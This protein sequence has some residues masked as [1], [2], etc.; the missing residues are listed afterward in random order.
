M[1]WFWRIRAAAFTLA[2]A[3]VVH[4]ARYALAPPQN[5]HAA[6]AAHGYFAWLMPLTVMFLFLT[7]VELASRLHRSTAKGPRL[8]GKTVLWIVATASLSGVVLA[9]EAAEIY[10]SHGHMPSTSTLLGQGGWLIFPL[11]AVVGLALALALKGVARLEEWMRERN[12]KRPAFERTVSPRQVSIPRAA[13][14][15]ILARRLAGRA[16]P[17]RLPAS[18]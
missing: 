14:T 8:P 2:G 15:S 18:I 1:D 4:Q 5:H 11:S 16:P 13:T 17:L 9:Q 12:A 7:A 3:L 10:F 6:E